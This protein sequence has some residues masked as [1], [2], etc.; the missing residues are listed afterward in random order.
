MCV[1]VC[2]IGAMVYM[3]RSEVMEQ[4]WELVFFSLTSLIRPAS[5]QLYVL[6]DLADPDM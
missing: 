4:S 1:C 5:K 3:R 6:N 2:A